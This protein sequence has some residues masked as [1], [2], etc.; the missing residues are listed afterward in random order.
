MSLVIE[1][2]QANPPRTVARQAGTT[3]NEAK[4]EDKYAY[5]VEG[6][7]T[8]AA[9]VIVNQERCPGPVLSMAEEQ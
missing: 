3:M 2:G 6:H 7:F 5:V 4:K 9:S 1:M 8:T